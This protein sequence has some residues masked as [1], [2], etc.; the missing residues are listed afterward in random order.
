M[1]H[2]SSYLVL[3]YPL[4]V[5]LG[6]GSSVTGSMPLLK[7][8]G[9]CLELHNQQY[10]VGHP[11]PFGGAKDTAQLG[12]TSGFPGS[13]THNIHGIKLII[14]LMQVGE[15][16]AICICFWFCWDWAAEGWAAANLSWSSLLST[17]SQQ[18]RVVKPGRELK[19]KFWYSLSHLPKNDK[20]TVSV[21]GRQTWEQLHSPVRNIS[22]H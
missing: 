1:F 21:D 22:Q 13:I 18:Y 7:I 16:R 4:A 17:T 14:G 8:E 19:S 12:S 9:K 11:S 15:F 5:H 3:L 6:F 10:Q 20:C 2:V